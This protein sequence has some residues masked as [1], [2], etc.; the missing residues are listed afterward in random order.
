M[1]TSLPPNNGNYSSNGTFET[2]FGGPPADVSAQAGIQLRAFF[3]NLAV[4][5]SLFA[6]AILAF[7]LL[8]SSAIGRRIYQPKTYLVQ[9]RLRVDAVPA[10]PIRW[11]RRIFSIRDDELKRK[12]GLDGYFFIRFLRAILLIFV[13]SM[14]VVVTVLL[15]INYN[16]GKGNNFHN[17][18]NGGRSQWNVA[19]LDTLSWQNVDPART[20]RYWAHLVC[21]ILVISWALFR[22]YREKVH[23]IDIRQRFLTSPEHRLKASARTI[24]VTNI[25]SEYRSKEALEALYDVFVD[26]DD[27]SRLVVWVN[28]DYKSLR[29][30]VARRRSLRHAL[31]KEELRIMRLCNKKFRK[32]GK[33]TDGNH[34]AKKNIRDSDIVDDKQLLRQEQVQ[35]RLTCIFEHDC[36]EETQLWRNYLKPSAASKMSLIRGKGDGWKPASFFKFWVS[37]ESRK[38]PKVAWLRTEIARLTI[39]I[40]ALLTELDSDALFKKQNSAFIQFDRQM[41][42]HMACSLVSHSKAGRMAPRF[43]EVA[44]HEVVWANMDVTSLGRLI[45]TCIALVLFVAIL[46]LWAIP[47]T[48]LGSLSQLASLSYSVGWLSWLRN[49]PSWILGLISGKLVPHRSIRRE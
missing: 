49:W 40:D 9:D 23:F 24:L 17:T 15:P 18:T 3:L 6:F 22:M 20:S 32:T 25:P 1:D 39:Q 13:P 44:P 8:K 29:K 19:G 42:A 5:L 14:I 38:A 46:L 21:A 33:V 41:A 4:S 43:L 45:R 34:T 10:D 48:I 7:F 26:N 36:S 16:K 47:T 12:C 2:W 37:G 11:I 30:L 28:R 31:E 27:R 35:Q